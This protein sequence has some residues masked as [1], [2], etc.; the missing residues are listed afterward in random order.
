[1]IQV[2]P[3]PEGGPMGA[4][5]EEKSVW[6]QLVGTLLG[7]A[8]YAAMSAGLISSG[9]RELPAYAAAFG[10]SIGMVVVAMVLGHVTVAIASRR[11]EAD[12]RDRLIAWKA[13]YRS[14]WLTAAGVMIGL[15]MMLFGY[16]T[17]WVA[18][19]LLVSLYV[20]QVFNYLLRIVYYRKGV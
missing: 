11:I 10:V 12:E 6:V 13:E 4:S 16:A 9:V 5:F 7:I 19:A 18:H 17:V 15:T 8:A 2:I 1:M 3:E 20:S 14:S